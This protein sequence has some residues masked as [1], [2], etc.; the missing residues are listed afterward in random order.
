MLLSTIKNL[1]LWFPESSGL[2]IGLTICSF[3]ISGFISS[4]LVYLLYQY[5]SSLI[6]TVLMMLGI[7]PMLIGL[8]L[9]KRSNLF[10]SVEEPN[11]SKEVYKIVTN[12]RFIIVWLILCMKLSA[13][14]MIFYN[15]ISIANYSFT[16][17]DYSSIILIALSSAIL[18]SL[19]KLSAPWISDFIRGS[20]LKINYY[21]FGLPIIIMIIAY[22]YHDWSII[23][24]VILI[25][26]F[27]YGSGLSCIP[28]IL[29]EVYGFKYLGTIQGL[30]FT[31]W[32]VAGVLGAKL[33]KDLL[34]NIGLNIVLSSATIMYIL[35]LILSMIL[36]YKVK[37]VKN[38]V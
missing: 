9:I 5:N 36:I 35:G 38:K 29:K 37:E 2:P 21:I 6:L 27:M 10:D 7:T 18:C 34:N 22:F 20:K 15:M 23:P 13:G 26:S 32:C 12:W 17:F 33:G 1:I 8:F 4:G 30:M 25:S 28:I 19:G 31:S 16:A 3:N 14:L 11:T 24:F